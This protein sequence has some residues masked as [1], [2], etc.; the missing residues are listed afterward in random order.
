MFRVRPHGSDDPPAPACPSMPAFRS[1]IPPSPD[2]RASFI[3][4][5][6]RRPLPTPQYPSPPCPALNTAPPTR[7]S[8]LLNTARSWDAHRHRCCPS[9]VRSRYPQHPFDIAGPFQRSRL[10]K[11]AIHT[12][13]PPA[14]PVLCYK[15]PPW[16]LPPPTPT[17]I[18]IFTGP[19]R[20]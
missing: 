14:T 19:R 18:W 20:P 12:A 1:H 9:S 2:S 16:T 8:L 13:S 3:Y 7:S 5:L 4:R 11:R 6:A 15:S 10:P 17:N